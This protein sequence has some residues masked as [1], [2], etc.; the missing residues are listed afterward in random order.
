MPGAM[1]RYSME[2]LIQLGQ[3]RVGPGR[4]AGVQGGGAQTSNWAGRPRQLVAGAQVGVGGLELGV[5]DE[6]GFRSEL[7][8]ACPVCGTDVPGPGPGLCGAALALRSWPCPLSPDGLLRAGRSRPGPCRWEFLQQWVGLPR[9]PAGPCPAVQAQCG[10]LGVAAGRP[11]TSEGPPG[12][13]PHCVPAGQLLTFPVPRFLIRLMLEQHRTHF[14][15]F[16]GG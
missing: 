13:K 10:L 14:L 7:P 3:G 12:L 16:C 1:D 4:A 5:Q 15:G 6:C 8:R 2:E 11:G 9:G